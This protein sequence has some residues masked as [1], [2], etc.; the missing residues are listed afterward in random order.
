MILFLKI[1]LAHLLGDF[2]LQPGSW[3]R[4]KE[5]KKLKAI[6]LYL[7]ALLHGVLLMILVA[8]W[9][10]LPYAILLMVLHLAIDAAKLYLQRPESARFYFFMDQL[11][12]LLSIYGV[13]CMYSGYTEWNV[14]ALVDEHLLIITL[15]LFLTRPASFAI[16][17]FIARW[18]P[19]TASREDHSLQEAGMYI[20]I[21]ERLFVFVFILLDVWQGV[22]F[23]LAA[24]SIFRFGDLRKPKDRRLTEYIL[25]GTLIS[26]G[27]AVVAALIYEAVHAHYPL[28]G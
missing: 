21:L 19:Q 4:E 28:A 25:I 20:C 7:H 24:K 12:H 26:F 17:V 2:F 9:A 15:A 1:I 23:L 3:V 18:A 14:S 22:G 11:A 6:Q 10:F 16:G 5:A 27:L 13:F 8:E